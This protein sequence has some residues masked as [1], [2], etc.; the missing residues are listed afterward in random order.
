MGDGNK[1]LLLLQQLLRPVGT[2]LEGEKSIS[3]HE[4]GPY[5]NLFCAHP[6]FQIDGNFGGTA[7]ILEMLLQSHETESGLPS[8]HILPALPV[9]WADGHVA[10]L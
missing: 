5:P 1:A 3:F 10:G 8:I 9:A 4:G 2:A 6:P 7:A